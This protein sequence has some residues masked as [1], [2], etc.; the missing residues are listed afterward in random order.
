MADMFNLYKFENM[1]YAMNLTGQE[2][3]G[4]LELSY[5]NWINTL[6]SPNDHLLKFKTN[7]KGQLRLANPAYNFDS[8]AGIIYTV[9]VTKPYG[10]RI[11]ILSL[12]NGEKF[13]LNRT[14]KVA[15]NSYR[16]NGGGNLLTDGAGIPADQLASRIIWATDIDLRYHMMQQIKRAGTI[17]PRPLNHWH[18]I[19]EEIVAP[20]IARDYNLLFH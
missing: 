10:L 7:D 17:S 11:S 5:E 1:L 6:S 9:D 15:V 16:G 4:H 12:A 20:T 8:A 14:Y 3:K 19:P 13:D 18:F 2:I